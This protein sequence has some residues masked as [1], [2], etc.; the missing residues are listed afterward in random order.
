MVINSITTLSIFLW[1][2]GT[3]LAFS[4]H[5]IVPTYILLHNRL[6]CQIYWYYSPLKPIN[7]CFVLSWLRNS[8]MLKCFWRV[9]TNIWVFKALRI[10]E[11]QTTTWTPTTGFKYP[12]EKQGLARRYN[13]G[14]KAIWT[15]LRYSISKDSA[16][17]AS[18]IASSSKYKR[19]LQS[20]LRVFFRYWKHGGWKTGNI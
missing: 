10:I 7:V 3:Q 6:S 14:C 15:W 13:D 18:R 1:P 19:Q 9:K 4:V 12:T 5:R 11:L 16:F 8:R 20:L 2:K 17:C